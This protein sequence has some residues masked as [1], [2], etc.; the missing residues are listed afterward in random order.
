MTS[1]NDTSSPQ[2]EGREKK[3]SKDGLRRTGIN[4]ELAKVQESP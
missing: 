2:I 3:K 1:I 4:K